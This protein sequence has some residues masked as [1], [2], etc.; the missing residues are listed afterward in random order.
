[1]S[2]H[3][4]NKNR[5]AENAS[6]IHVQRD[7]VRTVS[8]NAPPCSR[9]RNGSYNKVDVTKEPKLN[10]CPGEFLYLYGSLMSVVCIPMEFPDGLTH[11][12]C[13]LPSS[14]FSRPSPP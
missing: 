12:H 9:P 5:N 7:A 2:Y 6:Y 14:S 1:M 11:L 4:N 10:L 3:H 13:Y 8:L